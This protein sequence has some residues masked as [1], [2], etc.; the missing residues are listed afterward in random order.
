MRF[1]AIICAFF[2]LLPRF[3]C[4]IHLKT[5]ILSKYT[6][7][8]HF[9]STNSAKSGKLPGHPVHTD[10]RCNIFF[11]LQYIVLSVPPN[12]FLPYDKES[13][14]GL[15]AALPADMPLLPYYDVFRMA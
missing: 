8:F 9:Y 5:Y 6:H 4:S 2:A 10:F 15:S 13:D 1:E 12:A 3:L 11:L 14:L 7:L